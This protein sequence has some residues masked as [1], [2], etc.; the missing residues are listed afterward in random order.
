MWR[1]ALGDGGR[2]PCS[3]RSVFGQTDAILEA[4]GD[5]SPGDSAWRKPYA[6]TLNETLTAASMRTAIMAYARRNG[7]PRVALARHG[8]G[9]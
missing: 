3:R 2:T 8:D 5:V 1:A 6:V 4:L 7:R 9:R